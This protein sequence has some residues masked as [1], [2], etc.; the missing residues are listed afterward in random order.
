ML[1]KKLKIRRLR[2]HIAACK[3]VPLPRLSR[4]RGRHASALFAEILTL[5]LSSFCGEDEEHDPSDEFEEYLECSVCGDNAHRQCARSASTLD[6]DEEASRWRCKACLDTGAEADEKLDEEE[7]IKPTSAASKVATELLPGHRGNK[8]DSHSVF[9]T[10]I[11]ENDPLDGSRSLRKRKSSEADQQQRP[12]R[13][14]RRPSDIASTSAGALRSSSPGSAAESGVISVHERQG[15]SDQEDAGPT[16]PRPRRS[17]KFDKP[18]VHVVSAEGISLILSF[19]LDR[20]HMQK[21]INSRPREK[22]RER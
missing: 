17:R 6:R 13:K 4:Q 1:R 10:L 14:R 8:P 9:N 20:E 16:R 2:I 7:T 22:S 15:T 12:L 18:A 21:I 11:L 5:F 19:N 3:F